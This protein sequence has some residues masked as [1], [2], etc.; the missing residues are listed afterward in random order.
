[1]TF[2]EHFRCGDHLISIRHCTK[3][4][5]C[6]VSSNPH[7]SP[8]KWAFI[9]TIIVII[10]YYFL[11]PFYRWRS[12]E[13]HTAA[14]FE[15]G[16]PPQAVGIGL[17]PQSP[18]SHPQCYDEC[19][20]RKLWNEILMPIMFWWHLWLKIAFSVLIFWYKWT[21]KQSYRIH[22]NSIFSSK[23]RGNW[24]IC[25]TAS[26]EE[27]LGVLTSLWWEA[28]PEAVR[29]CSCSLASHLRCC[30]GATGLSKQRKWVT[31]FPYWDISAHCI[32]TL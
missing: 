30:K 5:S 10:S 9:V 8:M 18:H 15:V 12:Q 28:L 7:I 19:F 23:K 17:F 20:I 4:F 3:G 29:P 26:L 22:P 25:P 11:F 1:M 21:L 2:I 32:L 14:T 31:A 24:C 27:K 13:S 16:V 6:I